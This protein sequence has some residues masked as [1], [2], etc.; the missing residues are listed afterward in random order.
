MKKLLAILLSAML[1]LS[2]VACSNDTPS[3]QTPVETP[4]ELDKINDKLDSASSAFENA[5]V[6]ENTDGSKVQ[7]ITEVEMDGY[8]IK[9]GTK[10][11]ASDGTETTTALTI[12]YK[13]NGKKVQIQDTQSEKVSV[14]AVNADGEAVVLDDEVAKETT[15][16]ALTTAKA[17]PASQFVRTGE[18][19]YTYT[20]ASTMARLARTGES[21][22]KV[23]I[24][25]T[26]E[27]SKAVYTYEV[28]YITQG[29]TLTV[30]QEVSK[31][32][33]KSVFNETT[34]KFEDANDEIKDNLMNDFSLGNLQ[35]G[36]NSFYREEA[37]DAAYILRDGGIDVS[38]YIPTDYTVTDSN[39]D[40][41]TIENGSGK[42]IAFELVGKSSEYVTENHST[43]E[44]TVNQTVSVVSF[45][46]DIPF[47][48]DYVK[49]GDKIILQYEDKYV[50]DSSSST[51][52]ITVKD[53]STEKLVEVLKETS[54]KTSSDSSEATPDNPDVVTEHDSN[55]TNTTIDFTL[56]DLQKNTVLASGSIKTKDEQTDTHKVMVNE[57]GYPTQTIYPTHHEYVTTS[58]VN[59]ETL[60]IEGLRNLFELGPT[61]SLVIETT[62]TSTHEEN[63]FHEII[64]EQTKT[65]IT[66]NDKEID[67][68]ALIKKMLGKAE[69]LI[70]FANEGFK[71]E[72]YGTAKPNEYDGSY[73]VYDPK[74]GYYNSIEVKGITRVETTD[75]KLN[76]KKGAVDRL[77]E[78]LEAMMGGSGS[79]PNVNPNDFGSGNMVFTRDYTFDSSFFGA[80]GVTF[81]ENTPMSASMPT[82]RI[83]F[84]DGYMKGAYTFTEE[85]LWNN[86]MYY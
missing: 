50:N 81:V 39:S 58:T 74:T 40:K 65:T 20:P 71:L 70:G 56:T 13:E 52:T 28:T 54:T 72:Y 45:D 82:Y 85:E 77:V 6:T 62:Q 59:F 51:V 16:T 18:N 7:T 17:I 34:G 64:N 75:F 86:N 83:E 33:K 49:A 10:T 30:T 27:D 26:Y 21:V 68:E 5:E 46:I 12:E 60:A 76:I 53:G 66:V 80:K 73:S 25:F 48:S 3:P 69:S 23:V 9:E 19:E 84:K 4:T 22:S 79:M 15:E 36:G 78:L 67:Y 55:I 14:S 57:D 35:P 38:V 32:T 1:V 2:M 41:I 8:T 31:E 44:S 42:K 29:N 24:S 11:V 37:L 43:S 47:I 63:E 61:D